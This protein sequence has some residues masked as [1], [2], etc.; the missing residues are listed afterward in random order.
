MCPSDW[1]ISALAFLHCD[2]FPL[3][4][5]SPSFVLSVWFSLTPGW[6]RSSYRPRTGL[7]EFSELSLFL[8]VISECR[9]SRK[10][11]ERFCGFFPSVGDW[12]GAKCVRNGPKWLWVTLK[13]R[14]KLR[15]LPLLV[16]DEAVQSHL[17]W[18][19]SSACLILLLCGWLL[20][21]LNMGHLACF[22][23]DGI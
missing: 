12:C 17:F 2:L 4:G 9:N 21:M 23:G 22:R 18:A 6:G 7:G 3:V 16:V 13:W 14:K 15:C 11:E 10:M 8:S 1:A 20:W 5:I 19:W